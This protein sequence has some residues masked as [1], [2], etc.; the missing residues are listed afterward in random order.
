MPFTPELTSLKELKTGKRYWSRTK[1]K[2]FTFIKDDAGTLHL[3]V[4]GKVE[5]VTYA[6]FNKTWMRDGIIED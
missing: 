1:N 3:G 4:N 6:V 5:K 2:N